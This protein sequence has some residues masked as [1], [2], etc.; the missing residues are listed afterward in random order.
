[1]IDVPRLESRS[2]QVRYSEVL[3]LPAFGEVVVDGRPVR[4]GVSPA[5]GARL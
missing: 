5:D 3:G 4:W 1:M 2:A